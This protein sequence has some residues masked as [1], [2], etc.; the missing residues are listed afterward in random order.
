M[1]ATS[2]SGP[3]SRSPC[4]GRAPRRSSAACTSTRRR[5]AIMTAKVR[6]WV[7][8]DVAGLRRPAVRRGVALAGGMLAVRARGI[9]R[10]GRL[11][12]WTQGAPARSRHA[13]RH[14]GH[15][16]VRSPANWHPGAGEHACTIALEP[17]CNREHLACADARLSSRAGSSR[18][19]RSGAR[20][21][22]G[23][24]TNGSTS[25]QPWVKSDEFWSRREGSTERRHPRRA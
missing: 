22:F 4:C 15:R 13:P 19:R 9:C 5:T 3:G 12:D 6:S 14:S 2:P 18:C 23:A 11:A 20:S 25:E 17:G 21:L 16:V 8:A 10:P 24:I 7:R 1:R